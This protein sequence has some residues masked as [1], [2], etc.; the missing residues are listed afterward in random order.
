MLLLL[1]L[2]ASADKYDD[3]N[4]GIREILLALSQVSVQGKDAST[5]SQI[6]QALATVSKDVSTL[7][8]EQKTTQEAADKCKEKK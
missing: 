7:Q 1:P 4:A 6:Q 8:K 5:F 2:S 3:V